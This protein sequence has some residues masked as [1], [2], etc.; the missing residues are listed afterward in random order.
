[1]DGDRRAF[2]SLL[3][4]GVAATL[5][6]CS[7]GGSVYTDPPDPHPLLKF[8]DTSK[9]ALTVDDGYSGAA[10]AAYVRLCEDTGLHLTFSA[11]GAARANWEPLA[12][13]IGSLVERGQVQIVNHT[14]AHKD[15]RAMSTK[16]VYDD[17]EKNEHWIGNKFKTTSRPYFRPPFGYYNKEIQEAAGRAGFTKTLLWETS[18]GDASGITP[19]HFIKAAQRA[20][21]GGSVVLEHANQ[22]SALNQYPYVVE[23][24]RQR[25][26]TPVR[27]NELF[28]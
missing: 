10:L 16:Q 5:S 7:S 1:M 11:V 2:L 17:L 9:V 15:L 18:F 27:V 6:S 25:Q 14:Y 12:Q 19:A 20:L 4:L 28:G 23:L 3:A 22:P 21:R 13:R 24:I 26:L 8:G